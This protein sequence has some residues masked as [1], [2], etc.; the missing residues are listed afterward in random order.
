MLLVDSGKHEVSLPDGNEL[1]MAEDTWRIFWSQDVGFLER[2]DAGEKMEG[3][4][5]VVTE[6]HIPPV[7]DNIDAVGDQIK[8][9]HTERW[10]SIKV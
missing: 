3:R 7:P 8:Q 1:H 9:Q 5:G 6:A 4:V 10:I 2:E